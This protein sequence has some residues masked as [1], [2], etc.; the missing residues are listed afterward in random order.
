MYLY[1]YMCSWQT[2]FYQ[3]SEQQLLEYYSNNIIV[4]WIVRILLQSTLLVH[5]TIIWYLMRDIFRLIIPEM[6]FWDVHFILTLHHRTSKSLIVIKK[7][8]NV[9]TRKNYVFH[10]HGIFSRTT[11]QNQIIPM[12]QNW[13]HIFF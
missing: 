13:Y 12:K 11:V 10:S 4:E 3:F 6:S 8:V 1:T 7:D 2:F 5:P 9:I